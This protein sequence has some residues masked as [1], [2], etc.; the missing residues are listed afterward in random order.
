MK[1]FPIHITLFTVLLIV[2]MSYVPAM[3]YE[4]RQQAVISGW[5][6]IYD[7]DSIF[8]GPAEIRLVGIDAPE[9][10]QACRHDDRHFWRCGIASRDYLI[11]LVAER[12]VRCVITG[13]DRYRRLLGVCYSQ[14]KDLNAAMAASGN[15]ISYH[16]F[17]EAYA[18]EERA[19][20][21][22]KIGI[23]QDTGFTEPFY[24]RHLD[25]DHACYVYDASFQTASRALRP[26]RGKWKG[27]RNP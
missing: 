16:Y 4:L 18:S 25:A 23:W 7:G 22:A 10:G 13:K 17:S 20:K 26:L 9:L 14:G 3:A 15:A 27:V 24:C 11:R 2:I 5:P 19:A 1:K 6:R 8:L 12:E 21:A